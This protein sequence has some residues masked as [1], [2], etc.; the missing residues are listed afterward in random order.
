MFMRLILIATS[1]ALLSDYDP[2]A[3]RFFNLNATIMYALIGLIF[4]M[5]VGADCS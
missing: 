1:T 5:G 4:F 2:K 3:F